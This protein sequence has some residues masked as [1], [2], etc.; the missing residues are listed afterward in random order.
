[1]DFFKKNGRKALFFFVI[2]ALLILIGY[3]FN[4]KG[5]MSKIESAVG[6]FFSPGNKAFSDMGNAIRDFFDNL[7]PDI[8]QDEENEK[9]KAEIARLEKENL[10]LK[11]I[12][13]ESE[14]LKREAELLEKTEYNMI[15][16]NLIGR[17]SG[18]IN[19]SFTVDV[20]KNDGVKINQAVVTAVKTDTYIVTEGLVGKVVDVGD[21]WTKIEMITDINN[22]ISFSLINTLDGGILNG[23][24]D[25]LMSGFMFDESSQPKKGSSCVTSG[26][27]GVYPKGILIGKVENVEMSSDG[28]IKLIYV[29]PEVDFMKLNRCFIIGGEK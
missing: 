17:D 23:S 19:H 25:G 16:A 22:S 5:G 28:L 20:G 8:S 27:G 15:E 7:Y 1:M 18:G 6:N 14:I 11:Q 4:R 9:L 24:E 21:D 29:K 13:W 26:I 3:S 2:I 12:V 10:Q